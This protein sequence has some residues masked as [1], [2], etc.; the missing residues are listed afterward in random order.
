MFHM[1][2]G[3]LREPF[4]DIGK[5]GDTFKIVKSLNVMQ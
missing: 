3:K 1:L 5:N 4:F 2:D